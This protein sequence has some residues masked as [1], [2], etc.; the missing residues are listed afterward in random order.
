M[1]HRRR[2]RFG[3]W[4]FEGERFAGSAGFVAW[5]EERLED[6]LLRTREE[7]GFADALRAWSPAGVE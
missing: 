5:L 7:T 4:E 6:L 2:R 1:A 3:G